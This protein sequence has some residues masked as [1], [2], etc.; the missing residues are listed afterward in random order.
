VNVTRC[1]GALE[2]VHFPTIHSLDLAQ[3]SA[4]G[5]ATAI[6]ILHSAVAVS[7]RIQYSAQPSTLEPHKSCVDVKTDIDH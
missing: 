7:G 1:H 6:L 5:N 4:I 2:S 3:L